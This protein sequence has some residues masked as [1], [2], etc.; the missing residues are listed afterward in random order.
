MTEEEKEILRCERER[1]KVEREGME[2]TK[3]SVHVDWFG[4]A[5]RYDSMWGFLKIDKKELLDHE[6]WVQGKEISLRLEG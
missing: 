2:R 4:M 5:L 6:C 1:G 3:I